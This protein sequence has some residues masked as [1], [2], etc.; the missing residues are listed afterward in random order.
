MTTGV[1]YTNYKCPYAL[2]A[3]IALERSAIDYSIREVLL[4]KIPDSLLFHSKKG[5]VP[6]F[7]FATGEVLDES[8]DIY[9]KFTGLEFSEF[10]KELVSYFDHDIKFHVDRYRRPNRYGVSKP[11]VHRNLA[12][13][14]LRKFDY[15]TFNSHVSDSIFPFVRQFVLVDE[16][17]F[18]SVELPNLKRWYKEQ[19]STKTFQHIQSHYLDN[20]SSFLI[21]E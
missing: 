17:W 16:N 21:E 18:E 15:S 13:K 6:V 12:V 2:R 19:E 1:L 8:R 14:M 9:E 10:E 11:S 7:V 4:S 3:I 20:Y 5:T